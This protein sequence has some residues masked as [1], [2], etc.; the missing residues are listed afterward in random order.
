MGPLRG[1]AEAEIREIREGAKGTEQEK[2]GIYKVCYHL[3]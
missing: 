1:E 3:L 2:E